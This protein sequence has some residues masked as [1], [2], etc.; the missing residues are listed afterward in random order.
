MSLFSPLATAERLVA[1]AN[2]PTM[3][4]CTIR[5]AGI[6]GPGDKIL[7]DHLVRGE[8]QYFLGDGTAVLDWVPVACVAHAHVLAEEALSTNPA[9]REKML[10]RAYFI[11]NNE[12]LSYRW[13]IGHG[14]TGSSP[15]VSHWEYPH[16]KSLPLGLVKVLAVVNEWFYFVVGVPLLPPTLS[17]VRVVI[18]IKIQSPPPDSPFIYICP[19]PTLQ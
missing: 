7:S 13:F 15:A 9:A 1:A 2:S 16:P 17:Q 18:A 5:P 6:F 11:G 4:T 19:P 3:A 8:D 14:S 10:Q 12:S